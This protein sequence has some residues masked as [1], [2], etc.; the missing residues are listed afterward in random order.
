M[1][2]SSRKIRRFLT[3]S[4]MELS[5]L[6]ISYVFGNVTFR[7]WKIKKI[8]L[9]KFLIFQKNRTYRIYKKYDIKIFISEGNFKIPL[10]YS[11]YSKCS[12][13]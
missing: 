9:K 6:I 8:S 12:E 7:A 10:K 11:E 5:N 4:E 1:E 13:N 3:F 2:L